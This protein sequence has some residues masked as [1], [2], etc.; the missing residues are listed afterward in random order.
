MCNR[1]FE[2]KWAALYCICVVLCVTGSL[3]GSGQHYVVLC[4]VLYVTGSL[5]GNGQHY[6]VLCVVLHVTGSLKGNG[7]HLPVWLQP[8][9]Y[10]TLNQ[11]IYNHAFQIHQIMT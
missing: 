5:K 11:N 7:Q 2:R 1:Q 10:K 9:F 8:I 4:V 6:V 3:K